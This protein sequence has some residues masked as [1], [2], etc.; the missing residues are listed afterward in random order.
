M[1]A[2]PLLTDAR[3]AGIVILG[4]G[5]AIG[6]VSPFTHA[7]FADLRWLRT[8]VPRLLDAADRLMAR[9][10]AA[11]IAAQ[12]AVGQAVVI[13]LTGGATQGTL[14]GSDTA[15]VLT[16]VLGI[17]TEGDNLRSVGAGA[18]ALLALVAQALV[19]A[20]A[21]NAT[22]ERIDTSSGPIAVLY[23]A[24][25]GRVRAGDAILGALTP[26]RLAIVGLAVGVRLT[27]TAP[28]PAFCPNQAR[29][30]DGRDRSEHSYQ[31]L[32]QHAATGGAA[33]QG[34]RE[35][36]EVLGVDDGSSSTSW[37]SAGN[38][39]AHPSRRMS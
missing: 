20:F 22:P 19:V 36:I 11:D 28:E 4:T 38:L 34:P 29:S 5:A 12:A 17:G 2:L 1:L 23:P 27:G 37:S 26:M 32:S 24:A 15:L 25:L 13:L 35:S 10:A 30:S 14:L 8:R 39:G 33:G 18:A 16:G 21:Q 9:R 3:L 31:H 7:A 6:L